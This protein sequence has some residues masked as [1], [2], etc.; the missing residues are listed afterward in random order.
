MLNNPLKYIDPLGLDTLPTFTFIYRKPSATVWIGPALI[1]LGQPLD[2][3]KPSGMLGSETGSS[4]ASWGLSKVFRGSIA[5]LKSYARNK[6]AKVVERKIARKIVNRVIGASVLGRL[7]GRL[8]PYVGWALFAHDLWDNRKIIKGVVSEVN[9]EN[10]A[11]K[12]NLL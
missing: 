6:F 10:E 1:G 7:F 5:P 2:F 8:V 11:N 4:I 3:L 12:D 9:K